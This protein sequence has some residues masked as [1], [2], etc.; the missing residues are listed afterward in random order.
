MN[1]YKIKEG[2]IK[3]EFYNR[4][5]LPYKKRAGHDVVNWVGGFDKEIEELKDRGKQGKL[6]RFSYVENNLHF[7]ESF[8]ITERV[9]GKRDA[10]RVMFHGVS[11]ILYQH[12]IR[13]ANYERFFNRALKLGYTPTETKKPSNILKKSE[14]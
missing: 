13:D 5:K 8:I 1:S 4:T 7:D 11:V 3:M 2:C 9:K 12:E 14:N 10:Y 6:F